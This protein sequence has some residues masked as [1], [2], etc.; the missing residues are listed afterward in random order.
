M[1]LFPFL[2]LFLLV[3]IIVVVVV[4]CVIKL[5]SSSSG[6]GGNIGRRVMT[7]Y[8]TSN[9]NH[10]IFYILNLLFH[11]F[12]GSE[13]LYYIIMICNSHNLFL[14]S[15]LHS[16]PSFSSFILFLYSRFSLP[17]L[18]FLCRFPSSLKHV[19]EGEPVSFLLPSLLF[20]SLPFGYLP[21]LGPR[22][23]MSVCS[24]LQGTSFCG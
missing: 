7:V 12:L 17:F 6:G 14:Y 1:V 5:S 23:L 9:P 10:F 8:I 18:S 15:F 21:L 13:S 16:L 11:I 22:I 20:P 19:R 3:V 24:A 2:L 4:V